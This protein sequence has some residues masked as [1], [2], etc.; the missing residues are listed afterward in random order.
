METQD[1]HL[2]M[3]HNQSSYRT[4]EEWKLYSPPFYDVNKDSSYRTYEEW[5]RDSWKH[6]FVFVKG[7]YRTYEEWKHER[8]I[9]RF[10][11]I[12]CSYRTYEEWKLYLVIYLLTAS[13]FVLTVPMRNGNDGY[14]KKLGQFIRFLPYL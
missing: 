2:H 12:L 3:K 14:V 1:S 9:E 4:Y 6:G 8:V 7:S 10:K 13:L 5:K 11:D